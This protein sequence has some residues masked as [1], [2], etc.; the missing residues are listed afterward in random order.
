MAAQAAKNPSQRHWTNPDKSER[1]SGTAKTLIKKSEEKAK[2]KTGLAGGGAKPPSKPPKGPTSGPNKG[3]KDEG[4]RKYP[5]EDKH[6][7]SMGGL[8]KGKG[9]PAT[10]SK[11][12][13]F[14]GKR[15][16]SYNPSIAKNKKK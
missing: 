10:P 4:K 9:T 5:S 2:P 7:N 3:P 16:E 11:D 12:K 15:E 13:Q 1:V 6:D 14:S 8:R